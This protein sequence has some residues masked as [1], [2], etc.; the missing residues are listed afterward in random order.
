VLGHLRDHYG[1]PIT[2]DQL[3]RLA[4]MSVRT[5]ERKFRSRFHLSP[6]KYLR[7]LRLRTA[8]RCLIYTRQSLADVALGCGF[9]DQSH[10]SREFRRHF[11]RTPR[12]YR[13]A[14]L[15]DQKADASGTNFVARE[16]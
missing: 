11:G 9:G 13:E 8:S 12:Q 3:A 14:Y 7:K 10:F 6:Q 1:E 2:N 4:H 16:Q 15:G 5:F